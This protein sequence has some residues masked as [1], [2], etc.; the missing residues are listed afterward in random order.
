[1]IQKEFDNKVMVFLTRVVLL[2]LCLGI[3]G[4]STRNKNADDN[5]AAANIRRLER[6]GS[7]EVAADKSV[8]P[9]RAQMLREA[10]LSIGARGGLSYRSSQINNIILKYESGL[11]RTFNFSGLMLDDN[12]LP[13]VL[14]ESNNTLKLS[15]DQTIRVSDKTFEIIAQAKF[16]TA[17]PT[18]KDY[19]IVN[20]QK[21]E[22]PASGLLPKTPGERMIWRKYIKKGWQAGIKQADSIFSEN[23]ARLTRDFKG[24]VRYHNLLAHNM[25]TPPY[26]AGINLGVTGDTSKVNIHDRVL[27]ITA[28]PGINI[29]SSQW[30][31]IV[32]QNE[33]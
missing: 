10:A 6:L 22:D 7:Y 23:I 15:N 16:I 25:V 26:V 3:A 27:R 20:F 2:S 12:V 17:A 28:L 30:K 21:P 24:M 29:D 9:L 13:P 1:M 33:R 5:E 4:C 18:W 8:S 19:L 11:T 31:T 32:S 14:I